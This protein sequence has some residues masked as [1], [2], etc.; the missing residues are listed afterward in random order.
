MSG[1]ALDAAVIVA[2]LAVLLFEAV[3]ERRPLYAAL[4]GLLYIG[5]GIILGARLAA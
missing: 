5:W 3:M 4:Y 1:D 2:L